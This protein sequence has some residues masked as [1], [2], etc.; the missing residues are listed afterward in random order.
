M[1]EII[2]NIVMYNLGVL[3]L[4]CLDYSHCKKNFKDIFFLYKKGQSF[5][6]EEEMH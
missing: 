4:Y 2:L 3:W 1:I 6:E 5:Q